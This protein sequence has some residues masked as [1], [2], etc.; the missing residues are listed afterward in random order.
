MGNGTEDIDK[1]GPAAIGEDNDWVVE[2]SDD[3]T[4][5]PGGVYIF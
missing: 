1:S 4:Y 3:E 5:N 2:C